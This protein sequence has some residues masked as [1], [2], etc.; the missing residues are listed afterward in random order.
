MPDMSISAL[1]LLIKSKKASIGVIGLGYVGLPLAVLFAK[2][3]FRVTGFARDSKKIELL[4]S[5]I[6]GI[7]SVEV[8]DLAELVKKE[9]LRIS[10]I[11]SDE[12]ELQDIYFVCVPTPVDEQK[13]PDLSAVRDVARRLSL[14]PLEGKL[15]INE[16]TVAPGTTREEFG[17]FGGHYYLACSPERIDPGNR[18][19]TVATIAKVVGGIDRESTKITEMLYRMALDAPVVTVSSP[20]A[21]EM[22]KMLE[23]T[24]RAVNIA[25]VNEFALLAEKNGL[26]IL[27]VIEAAK[28]KWS[29]HPHYPSVGV[30]GHCIPVDP[31]YLVEYG[32]KKKLK[33]PLIVQG[34][35]G[36]DAMT[37]HVAQKITS[38]YRKGMSV[39]MYGLTY[40][41][42]VKDIRESPSIR[43]A[44]L[45]KK[46]NVPFSVYDPLF[47]EEEI[48]RL[49]FVPAKTQRMDIVIIATDHDALKNDYKTFIGAK[50]IVI[51]GR[52]FFHKKVGKVVYGVGRTLL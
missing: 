41:K 3:G 36:N 46:R 4:K 23:N 20:E 12:F 52:N 40:K 33:L 7:E 10:H 51:D 17:D 43:L 24:Y 34:L 32:K 6:S 45:L 19:K 42:N 30:G 25:L 15:I 31:W 13:K 35:K 9:K 5:G 28:T 50:T 48:R 14:V 44:K 29:F 22:V 38:L 37:A 16:S 27:E 26:D 47:T 11:D 49:G 1:A 2:K 18:D 21:A 39:V 8:R